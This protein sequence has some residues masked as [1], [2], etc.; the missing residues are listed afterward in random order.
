MLA[1]SSFSSSFMGRVRRPNCGESD[2]GET[3]VGVF[4]GGDIMEGVDMAS[5]DG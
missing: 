3:V 1:T 5:E 2:L 4:S